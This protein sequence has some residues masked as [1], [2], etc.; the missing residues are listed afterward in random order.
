M[1]VFTG[2]T[3]NHNENEDKNE[4]EITYDPCLSLDMTQ[5]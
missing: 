3:I 5:I 4:K 1:S 2:F